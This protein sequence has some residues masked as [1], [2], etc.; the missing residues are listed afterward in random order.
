MGEA[1][2]LR[3]NS[4][5]SSADL[6]KVSSSGRGGM[7]AKVLERQCVDFM[8]SGEKEFY[9]K[10]FLIFLPCCIKKTC[11]CP[12]FPGSG[13]AEDSLFPGVVTGQGGNESK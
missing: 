10:L 6:Q 3:T 8:Q 5:S 4:K 12:F 1:K 13:S 7:K 9:I 11:K 2:E